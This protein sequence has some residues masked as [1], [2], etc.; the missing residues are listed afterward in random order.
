[1]MPDERT[2]KG[3]STAQARRPD[4]SADDCLEVGRLDKGWWRRL[5]TT[6]AGRSAQAARLEEGI[7]ALTADLKA[8]RDAH[9]SPSEEGT[10]HANALEGTKQPNAEGKK[11]KDVALTLIGEYKH[12]AVQMYKEGRYDLGWGLLHRA[13]ETQILLL[14][15]AEVGAVAVSLAAE[16]RADKL[17]GWRMRAVH[18]L[19]AQMHN[20]PA[21]LDD[22]AH[23]KRA[24]GEP[25]GAEDKVPDVK[26][27]LTHDVALVRQALAERN[28]HFADEYTTL[29]ITSHRRLWLLL[30]GLVLLVAFVALVLVSDVQ[31]DSP[32]TQ[33][34]QPAAD[35][36]QPWV[37]GSM[38]LL[39]AL[40]SVVSAIQR[41]VSEP[42]K[43]S[44]PVQL[45]S[46]TA[47]VTRP[48]IGAVAALT[49]LL[50]ALGGL[51]VPQTH[52]VPLMLLAALTA[53]L[54]ERLVVYR[55]KSESP[56]PR[57]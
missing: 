42:L 33:V 53:G 11:A 19:L 37:A 51:A 1:M 29:A 52:P 6:V 16:A 41:L 4:S 32:V 20:P 50:A 35:L 9:V 7:L 57:A 23:A 2:T 56:T 22:A 13:R 30:M 12:G 55:D 40:G 21:G 34:E 39:G 54:S 43:S 36:Q 28:R 44:T 8:A 17:K 27:S 15:E 24:G 10:K 49:V 5:K 25:T 46:F 26:E 47:T 14:T 18:S 31:L 3:T 48:L 38:L 45:G